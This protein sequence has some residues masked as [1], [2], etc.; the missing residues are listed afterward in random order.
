VAGIYIHIPL[1]RRKCN[2]C[3]FYSCTDIS[4]KEEIL[5]AIGREL[6]RRRDFLP[7]R[8]IDTIYIGGGTPSLLAPDEI[9]ALISRVLRATL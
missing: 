4:L 7:G 1:C 3:D 5:G 2:Y 8:Q 9:G 6:E